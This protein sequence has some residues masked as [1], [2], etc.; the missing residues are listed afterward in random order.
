MGKDEHQHL[1]LNI[2]T[3][4]AV[5]MD[6]SCSLVM[7]KRQQNNIENGITST[8]KKSRAFKKDTALISH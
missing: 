3:G 5:L 7:S 8:N 4:K 6:I 1:A 2:K